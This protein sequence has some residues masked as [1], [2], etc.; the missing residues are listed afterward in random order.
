MTYIGRDRY[1]P[2]S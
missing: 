2:R 1:S